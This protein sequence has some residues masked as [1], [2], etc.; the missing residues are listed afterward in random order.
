LAMMPMVGRTPTLPCRCACF[1]KRDARCLA[2][3]WIYKR[4]EAFKLS[5]TRVITARMIA[6]LTNRE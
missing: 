6:T 2:L 1:G 3:F 5:A 4:I